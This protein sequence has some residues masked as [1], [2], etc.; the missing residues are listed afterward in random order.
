MK[1]LEAQIKDLLDKRALR[2][3]IE[4]H[5]E[6]IKVKLK[7][8]RLELVHLERQLSESERRLEVYEKL[9]FRKLFQKVLGDKKQQHDQE[10]QRYLHLILRYKDCKAIIA[11]KEY[12]IKV[13]TEQLMR[14]RTVHEDLDKLLRKKRQY[15]KFR[16]P[17]LADEVIQLEQAIRATEQERKEI[18]EA[19]DY[20]DKVLA[21]LLNLRGALKEMKGWHSTRKSEEERRLYS[22]YAE[23]KQTFK[24]LQDVQKTNLALDNLIDELHDVSKLYNLDYQPATQGITQFLERL[25]DDLITDWIFHD[26]MDITINLV[27]ETRLKIKRIQAMLQYDR[28]ASFE[29]E[30][31][32]KEKLERFLSKHQL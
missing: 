25:C 22:N 8:R 19:M 17:A 20:G 12:E 1:N 6:G 16:K 29:K 11:A 32:E 4:I 3:K 24:L 2:K 28:E 31:E 23:K 14:L 7:D 26:E 13:L 5:L 30:A 15:L 9:S 27:E 18:D 21:Q 10:R